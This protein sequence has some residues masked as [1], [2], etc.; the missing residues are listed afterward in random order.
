M[1]QLTTEN[2]RNLLI[3]LGR[4]YLTYDDTAFIADAQFNNDNKSL[5]DYIAELEELKTSQPI[6]F[7][8]PYHRT[9]ICG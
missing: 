8:T 9:P 2:K 5:H 4:G 7:D 3:A 6:T 1:L